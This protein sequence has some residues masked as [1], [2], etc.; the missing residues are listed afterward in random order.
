MKS[1]LTVIG[2]SSTLLGCAGSYQSP[3]SIESKMHRYKSISGQVNKVPDMSVLA[4]INYKKK[5][6]RGPRSYEKKDIQAEHTN[7]KLYFLTLLTQYGTLSKYSNTSSV[8]AINICPSFHSILVDH[9]EKFEN[10]GVNKI[11]YKALNFKKLYSETIYASPELVSHYPEL[12]LPIS[13]KSLHPNVAEFMDKNKTADASKV[14]SKAIDIHL[15]KAHDEL[16]ELCETGTSSN[17]YIYE[18]LMTHIKRQGFTANKTNMRTLLK[19]SIFTNIAI[20]KSFEK[21]GSKKRGRTIA[22]TSGEKEAYSDAIVERLG[23]DWSNQ[24]F[25]TMTSKR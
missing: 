17:Y 19:T 18:N 14:M 2:I 5:V 22:S 12:M 9:K 7:K 15:N 16:S 11:S 4:G 6:G 8:S 24:Y 20:I 1:K 10:S 23:V 21:T 3:E 13:K 25:D